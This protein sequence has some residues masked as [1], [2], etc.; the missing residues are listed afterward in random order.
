VRDTGPG[1]TA[2]DADRLFQPFFTTKPRGTGLG[3]AISR[4]LVENFDGRLWL[5]NPGERGASFAFSL[6]LAAGAGA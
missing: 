1:V 5:E 2:A 6:P 4:R 3:L